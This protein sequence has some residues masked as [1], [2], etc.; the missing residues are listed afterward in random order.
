[1]FNCYTRIPNSTPFWYTITRF[2]DNWGFWFPHRLQWWI[3]YLGK[4]SLKIRTS[5]NFCFSF[6]SFFWERES[7]EFLK[8]LRPQLWIKSPIWAK[9]LAKSLTEVQSLTDPKDKCKVNRTCV[10]L[11]CNAFACTPG[12]YTFK[13][14]KL[15]KPIVILLHPVRTDI[16]IPW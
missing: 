12:L 3:C 5:K 15:C 1:M 11:S 7:P 9:S 16:L 6:F 14:A 4:K 13:L 8:M 2:P 10:M